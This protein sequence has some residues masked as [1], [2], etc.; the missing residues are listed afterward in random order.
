MAAAVRTLLRRHGLLEHEAQLLAL[1]AT[2]P[3]HLFQLTDEDLEELEAPRLTEPARRAF[4][5]L[6]A[7]AGAGAPADGVEEP[8]PTEE[9]L[10]EALRIEDALRTSEEGQRQFQA[11]ETQ[12]DA[13]WLFVAAEMQQQALLQAG[14]R[15]TGPNLDRL[16]DAALRNPALARYVRHNRCRQG[17]LRVG[18]RP[19]NISLL[20]LNGA[21]ARLLPSVDCD[22]LL[23]LVIVAGSYS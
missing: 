6:L 19:P 11:A 20:D 16:R 3:L 1:G 21:G 13:D 5:M 8:P 9:Q 17:D 22:T 10:K 12:D 15:P 18:D 4:A 14:I 2:S 23:P 7:G